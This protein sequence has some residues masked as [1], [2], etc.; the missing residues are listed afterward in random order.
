MGIG[1]P[2]SCHSASR[3]VVRLLT[4]GGSEQTILSGEETGAELPLPDVL[5]GRAPRR[6]SC[7]RI[8][9]DPKLT[10]TYVSNIDGTGRRQLM[11]ANPDTDSINV[12]AAA[13][14]LVMV[15]DRLI[16]ARPFTSNRDA[17]EGDWMVLAGPT[18]MPE[19][20]GAIYSRSRSPCWR[21]S[22]RPPG[23]ARAWCG[24]TGADSGSAN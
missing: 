9:G 24:T 23:M 19:R 6:C 5:T 16:Q 10:G 11:T 2:D 1:R 21:I 17:L 12:F 20:S 13:G 14:H 4:P 18:E 7:C 15:R 8:P 22:P 3:R